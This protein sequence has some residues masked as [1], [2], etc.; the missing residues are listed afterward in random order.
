MKRIRRKYRERCNVT[1]RGYRLVQVT[2]I[3]SW[4]RINRNTEIENSASGHISFT[5]SLHFTYF[6][7]ATSPWISTTIR[8][9]IAHLI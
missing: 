9:L 8:H 1:G 5:S 2:P 3:L 7:L 4:D 6:L